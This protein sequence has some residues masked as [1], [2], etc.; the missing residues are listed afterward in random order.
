LNTITVTAHGAPGSFVRRVQEDPGIAV[1]LLSALR[2]LVLSYQEQDG[3]EGEARYFKDEVDAA[4]DVMRAAE[5]GERPTNPDRVGTWDANQ[6]ADALFGPKGGIAVWVKHDEP[7]L[8]AR[9]SLRKL[10]GDF[11]E[12][13]M[14]LAQLEIGLDDTIDVI[15]RANDWDPEVLLEAKGKAKAHMRPLIEHTAKLTRPGGGR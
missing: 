9:S 3:E 14:M 6:A 10:S 7:T 12:C 13:A 4:R 11:V 5:G 2:K 8:G 15:C 1:Q